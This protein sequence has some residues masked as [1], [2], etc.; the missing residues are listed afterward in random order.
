MGTYATTTSRYPSD[1]K[2]ITTLTHTGTRY[3][4][5]MVQHSTSTAL[6]LGTRSVI[7]RLRYSMAPPAHTCLFR[8]H[9]PK[10]PQSN[11]LTETTTDDDCHSS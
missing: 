9:D 11:R 4:E 6:Q 8:F 3:R 7:G 10:R 2:Q 1:D 5:A